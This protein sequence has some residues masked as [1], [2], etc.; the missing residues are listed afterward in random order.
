MRAARDA[1]ANQNTQQQSAGG[2]ADLLFSDFNFAQLRAKLERLWE[3]LRIPHPERQYFT[4]QFLRRVTYF[5]WNILQ[6]ELSELAKHREHTI[7]VLRQIQTRE[8]HIVQLYNLCERYDARFYRKDAVKLEIDR[9]V[10]NIRQA[11]IDVLNAIQEWKNGMT[12]SKPFE[13]KACNYLHKLMNDLQFINDT[14]LYPLLGTTTANNPLIVGPRQ[15]AAVHDY[16]IHSLEEEESNKASDRAKS[17][18]LDRFGPTGEPISP[19]KKGAKKLSPAFE[20]EN[21]PDEWLD[22]AVMLQR[23]MNDEGNLR[24]ARFTLRGSQSW[25][26]WLA[27]CV[28]REYRIYRARKVLRL[29]RAER[30]AALTIQC[31]WRVCRARHAAWILRIRLWAVRRVQGWIRGMKARMDLRW[32]WRSV[33]V[34]QSWYRAQLGIKASKRQG[35]RIRA[36]TK[37]QT[38]FRRFSAM[39][40]FRHMCRGHQ[41]CIQIQC[42]WRQHFARRITNHKRRR[43][44]AARQIQRC[45]RASVRRKFHR[46]AIKMQAW[47]RRKLAIVFV[48]DLRMLHGYVGRIQR[49][50]KCAYARMELSKRKEELCAARTIQLMVLSALARIKV[51][52]QRQLWR[53]TSQTYLTGI[54]DDTDR[55]AAIMIQKSW[56]RHRGKL[57]TEQRRKELQNL[58]NQY[59]EDEQAERACVIQNWYR[60]KKTAERVQRIFKCRMAVLRVERVAQVHI[61]RKY[62]YKRWCTRKIARWYMERC[63]LRSCYQ[64]QQKLKAD[65]RIEDGLLHRKEA[66]LTIQTTVRRWLAKRYTNTLVA[67]EKFHEDCAKRSAAVHV[68]QRW[69]RRHRT[70]T[71]VKAARAK[72]KCLAATKIQSTWRGYLDRCAFQHWKM[73]RE[74]TMDKAARRIQWFFRC[75]V[76]VAG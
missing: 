41:A 64:Y 63:L 47:V 31:F 2:D 27:L 40:F 58:Q 11:T 44:D 10:A 36:A 54:Q 66:A 57:Q 14:P 61:W 15:L 3:D 7:Y 20:G 60:K 56:R 72:Q 50:W 30:T 25:K 21:V 6:T 74:E 13:W 1:L 35:T 69:W 4:D 37:M 73:Q 51:N 68:L 23:M 67:S 39:R 53:T 49:G 32:K 59:F 75:C 55:A 43:R 22:A 33:I 34:I 29:L 42:A 46:L 9:I 16:V 17:K 5:N 26:R 48:L 71:A 12:R 65:Q 52:K 19:R 38:A 18:I 76:Q 70:M 62:L 45:W 8:G 24:Q 28:L